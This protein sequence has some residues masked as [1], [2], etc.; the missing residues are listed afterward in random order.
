MTEFRGEPTA[1]GKRFAIVVS[2]FNIVVTDRLLAGAR[3]CLNQHGVDDD[4][5]DVVSV[6][7]AWELPAA[8]QLAAR[9]GGYAAIV[10]IGCVVRGG[11]PHFDFVAAAATEGLGRVCLEEGVPIALGVLTTDDAEQ[12]LARAGGAHGNKGWDAALA[13]LELADLR[14]RMVS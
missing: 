6:P 8:A 13:A 4:H 3:A 2:R 5:I 14:A 7:G 1:A 11:T 10:A 12:A 9:R